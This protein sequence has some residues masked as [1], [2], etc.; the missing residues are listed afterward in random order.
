MSIYILAEF[1][2]NSARSHMAAVVVTGT[3]RCPRLR[4]P[5]YIHA[6]A[7]DEKP[8]DL[9]TARCTKFSHPQRDPDFMVK[10]CGLDGGLA[11]LSDA[12]V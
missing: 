8:Q 11:V 6:L 4:T 10:G 2:F 1:R 7:L 9:S 12:P 3:Y 5:S